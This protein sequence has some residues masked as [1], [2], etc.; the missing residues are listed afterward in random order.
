MEHRRVPVLVVG[1]G[2]AGLSTA[3]ML[4]WREIPVMLVER[5]PGTSIQTKAFGVGP[6]AVEL[7][8][9]VPGVEQALA[10]V[11]A[12]IGDNMRIA[13]GTSLSDPD[14]QMIIADEKE[15]F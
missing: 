4:A 11:W 2:Y 15:E 6:R 12:G 8:R 3:M 7:M 14:P 5:H 13:I 1:G 10:D 9:P